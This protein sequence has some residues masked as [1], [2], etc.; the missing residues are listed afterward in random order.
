MCPL[1]E[2]AKT[3]INFYNQY[4]NK[5]GGLKWTITKAINFRL[6]RTQLNL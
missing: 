6:Q 5:V 4:N 2:I 3:P 1:I